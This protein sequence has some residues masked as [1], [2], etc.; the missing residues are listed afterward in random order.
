MTWKGGKQTLSKPQLA[1]VVCAIVL[2]GCPKSDPSS[3]EIAGPKG[4]SSGLVS[5]PPK[6]VGPGLLDLATAPSARKK[7]D[8][9]EYDDPD[10]EGDP[11]PR[12][13]AGAQE[14]SHP[15]SL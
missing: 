15:M 12:S 10:P 5:A 2:Q 6:A 9:V 7:P 13:D 1:C 4:A 11:D 14:K 3:T 8:P